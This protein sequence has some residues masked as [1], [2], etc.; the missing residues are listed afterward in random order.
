MKFKQIVAVLTGCPNN[1]PPVGTDLSANS[2]ATAVMVDR[3]KGTIQV[4]SSDVVPFL[5]QPGG[6]TLAANVTFSDGRTSQIVVTL[7]Q[8]GKVVSL[9]GT[10]TAKPIA[11]NTACTAQLATTA[12]PA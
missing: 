8:D 1:A 9:N 5:L 10:S 2:P 4:G 6:Q 12:T 3:Q 11:G 7:N